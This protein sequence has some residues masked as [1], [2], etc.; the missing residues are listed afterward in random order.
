MAAAVPLPA[1]VPVMEW[2]IGQSTPG[3][4]VRSTAALSRDAADFG[5]L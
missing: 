3:P 4:F 5:H 2:P 1:R